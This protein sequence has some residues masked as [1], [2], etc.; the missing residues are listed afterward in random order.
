MVEHILS[1]LAVP[2]VN[3]VLLCVVEFREALSVNRSQLPRANHLGTREQDV[4]TLIA[5]H[6]DVRGEVGFVDVQIFG[7]IA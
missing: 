3:P 4:R 6:G 7:V 5:S 1:F 2:F